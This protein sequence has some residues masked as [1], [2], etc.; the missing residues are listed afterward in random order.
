[1]APMYYRGATAAIVAYD[2]TCTA[3]FE[4]AKHWIRELR[5]KGCADV[6]IALV[7]NKCDLDTSRAISAKV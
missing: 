4:R 1:L 5:T 2:I 7:G 3:S 6:L